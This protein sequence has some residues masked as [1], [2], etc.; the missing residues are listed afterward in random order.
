MED[1]S[2]VLPTL[3]HLWI[4]KMEESPSGLPPG[5]VRRTKQTVAKALRKEEKVCEARAKEF[6]RLAATLEDN[7]D[8]SPKDTGAD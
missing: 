8:E 1:N 7:D 4:Q 5:L 2:F 3:M 6:S